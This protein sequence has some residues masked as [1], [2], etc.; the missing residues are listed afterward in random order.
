MTLKLTQLLSLVGEMPAYR[1]LVADLE[2]KSGNA[3]TAVLDA[4]KP[5]LI[6]ALHQSLRLP[7]LVVTAQPENAKRLYEQ[8]STWCDASQ[9]RLFPELDT[10]YYDR[11]ASDNSIDVPVCN[12]P[13]RGTINFQMPWACQITKGRSMRKARAMRLLG[14]LD[15]LAKRASEYLR[16]KNKAAITMSAI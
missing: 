11:I 5:Y 4:A 12:I 10:L 15:R 13:S 16:Q 1:R 8:I 7:M 14:T 2:Q 9:S 3:R 6:A